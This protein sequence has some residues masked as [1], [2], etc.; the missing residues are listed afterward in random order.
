MQLHYTVKNH[1]RH[2]IT[3]VP[4]LTSLY[5]VECIVEIDCYLG[6]GKM[7]VLWVVMVWY[8]Y[9]N[10]WL[11]LPHLGGKLHCSCEWLVIMTK[12]AV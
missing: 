11:T 1:T 9:S 7:A 3:C 4:F 10:S 6:P 8:G 2:S 5:T 12:A